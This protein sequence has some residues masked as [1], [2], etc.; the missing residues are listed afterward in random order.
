[1]LKKIINNVEQVI[2]G[3]REAIEL[4][5]TALISNGHILLEDVPGV[6]KTRLIAAVARSIDGSFKRIQFTADVLPSDITGFSVYNQKT[7][8][9]EFKKG[10]IMSQFVLADEINR[11]SPKTQA[12]LLEAMEERQIS[13]DGVTYK[14]PQPF[15][16][17]ATQNPIEFMGTFPLP[18]A[19]LDRFLIKISVGYPDAESER[20]VLSM[21]QMD[22]PFETL[23]AVATTDDIIN[24]QN[25]VKKVF[26]H[27]NLESYIVSLVSATRN[28]P[29]VRL[30]ASPR[31]SLALY[32]TAQAT[33][34]IDGRDYVV[35]DDIQKMMIPVMAH[36]IILSQETKFSNT[37]AEDV[38]EEIKKSTPVPTG[39]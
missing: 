7:G 11:T 5:V 34:Y 29:S 31:A 20:S 1:M 28:H 35:P 30:G 33:A 4:V 10:A 8:D 18:E 15:M 22:D 13:V 6:G 39:K 17:M 9:F 14:M 2:V 27:E 19:Q 38:L 21:H 12:A 16:V 24:I 32:R 36:R 37:T 26:V 23:E 3:K 25:E